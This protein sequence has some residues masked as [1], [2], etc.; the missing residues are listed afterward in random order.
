MIKNIMLSK[1]AKE[2]LVE[3]KISKQSV[4]DAVLHPDETLF[5][6]EGIRIAHKKKNDK[7]LR[8]LFREEGLWDKNRL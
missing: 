2:K 3:R 8:V 6:R 7:M 1:H 4:E 5:G